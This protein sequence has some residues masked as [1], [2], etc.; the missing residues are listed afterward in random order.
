MHTQARDNIDFSWV[1]PVGLL[2]IVNSLEF[3]LLLLVEVTHLGE[4]LRISWHFGHQNVVPLK[5]LSSHTDQ[6]VNMSNLIDDFITVWDDSVKLL[7]GLEGL[8]VVIESLIDQTKVVNGLDAISFDTNSLK[9][10]FF[11]SV[12]VLKVVEAVSL[13][14]EGFG[15][16]SVVLNSEISERFSTLEIVFQEVQERDVVRSHSHHDLVFLLKAFETLDSS[17]DLLVL[18]V[19]DA[20]SDL[21]LTLN[22]WKVSGLKGL[23]SI[24]ITIND[25]L[26][27]ERSNQFG[28]LRNVAQSL[29]FL[30]LEV[31]FKWVQ[32]TNNLVGLVLHLEELL[33]FLL[34]HSWNRD[35]QKSFEHCSHLL[36]L[37]KRVEANDKVEPNIEIW[38]VIHNVLIDFN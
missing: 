27:D 29:L 28:G 1:I 2:V 6:L 14:D 10:E 11:G 25:V 34:V 8:I 35:H 22:L 17:F 19:M 26:I 18:D 9:E 15:V 16:V 33:L 24:V 21:H 5:S 7:K 20:L 37:S 13:V 31:L 23:T 4:D 3:I 38:S 12:V 30:L 32:V 36:L